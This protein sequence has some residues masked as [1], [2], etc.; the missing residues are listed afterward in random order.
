MG[1]DMDCSET[2]EFLIAKTFD[3]MNRRKASQRRLQVYSLDKRT[4]FFFLSL[5]NTMKGAQ[6]GQGL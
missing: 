6:L 4:S 2:Q 5:A 1:S 3:F